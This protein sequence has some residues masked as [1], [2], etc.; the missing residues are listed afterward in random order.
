MLLSLLPTKKFPSRELLI[1]DEAH[2]LEKEIVGFTG[3]S[4]S[5][6]WKRYLPNFKIVDYGY[7][8]EKW[9]NFLIELQT[10][11]LDLTGNVSEELAVEAI[12]DTQKLTRAIDYICSNP[13]NWIVSEIK[14]ENNEVTGVQLKPLDVSP[15]C[16]GVFEKCD[17]TLM[18]SATILDKD[19]FCTSLGL[20]SEELKFIRVPSDFPLQNRP[21]I[22]S[23]IAYLNSDTLR[24]EKV[25]IKIAGAIDNLMTLYKNDKGIIHTTSYKQ[26]DFIKENISQENKCRLL[27]TNPE[28]QRDEVIAEHVNSTKPTVLISP[29]LYTGLDLKDDLS[30]FQI[31]T[32]VP[33]PDLGDRWINEKKKRSGQWYNWQTALMLVQA[34]GRSVRSKEDYAV[35]YVL[36]SGFENFVWRNKHIL[37]DWFTQAIQPLGHGVSDS[38]S[39]KVLTPPRENH[40]PVTNNSSIISERTQNNNTTEKNEIVSAIL[41]TPSDPSLTL[42]GLY[43]NDKD[44]SNRQDQ[45]FIC[46][47][48]SNFKTTLE[49]EYQ[50]HI[51]LKHPRKPGYPNTAVVA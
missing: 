15:Y 36:D 24:Q 12:T 29:S 2:L 10:H 26:L 3:I 5:K 21:I 33:Y 13:K 6:R 19:A 45:L 28:I 8:I 42:A 17:K 18:M 14:K 4:I 34:Y 50:R 46:P 23:N 38:D 11:M 22:P 20:A 31:I 27:E 35:T 51:V 1:L 37:P 30:R 32:K 41:T 48:C 7:E 9:I 16:K 40:N 49:R 43:S 25:Q 47:Y 39:S 44:E